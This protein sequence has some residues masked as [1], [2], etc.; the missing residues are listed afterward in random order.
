MPLALAIL[1]GFMAFVWLFALAL[2]GWALR[3]GQLDGDIDEVN[4]VVFRN[5]HPAPWPGREHAPKEM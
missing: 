1:I 3:D 5:Q 4:Y 2:L